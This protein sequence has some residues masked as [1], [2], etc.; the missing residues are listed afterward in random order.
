VIG[1]IGGWLEGFMIGLIVGGVVVGS[2]VNWL[3][4]L[5]VGSL[6]G[7]LEGWTLG[8]AVISGSRA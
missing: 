1:S 2:I 7:C 3:E 8:M 6:V 4:G 5:A